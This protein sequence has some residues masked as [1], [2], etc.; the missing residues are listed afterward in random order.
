[1][2]AALG[3]WIPSSDDD[4]AI[5][6]HILAKLPVKNQLIATGLGHLRRR[7]QLVK[8][9]NAFPGGREKLGWYPFGLILGNTR[10]TPEI[11]RVK[12]HGPH[13]EKVVVEIVSDLSNDLRLSN[14]ART[15]DMQGHTFANERMERLIEL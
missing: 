15:P 3:G 6:Q 11:D 8:K 13:I 5:R 10:Q 2:N 1:M 9:E 4:P 12:L 14:A 7:G